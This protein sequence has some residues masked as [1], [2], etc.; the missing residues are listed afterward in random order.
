[1]GQKYHFDLYILGPQ[2]IWSLYFGTDP[3]GPCYFQF[4]VN[5]ILTFN[6]L[7]ENTKRKY[8]NI[9]L[10]YPLADSISHY[11]VTIISFVLEK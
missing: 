9:L 7:M 2:S 6:L 3:F 11:V 4:V 1:M 8:Q 10:F 5:L